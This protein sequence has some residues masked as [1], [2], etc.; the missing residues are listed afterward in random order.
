MLCFLIAYV[1]NLFAHNQ[2]ET[3]SKSVVMP[4]A[5]IVVSNELKIKLFQKFILCVFT[6]RL[7]I[8][9]QYSSNAYIQPVQIQYAYFENSEYRSLQGQDR[10]DFLEQIQAND[11]A[12]KAVNDGIF[13]VLMGF[14][15]ELLACFPNDYCNIP[16]IVM[17]VVFYGYYTFC[18]KNTL[19]SSSKFFKKFR[20][21]NQVTESSPLGE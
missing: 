12:F 7:K 6:G 2:F 9:Q 4:T 20:Q 5:P 16:L 8:H 19:K 18:L 11:A 10:T 17:K 3:P 15:S 14:A 1:I 21:M 13:L